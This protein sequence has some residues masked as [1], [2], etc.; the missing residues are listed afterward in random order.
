VDELWLFRPFV[1]SLTGLFAP[2]LFR[3]LARSPPGLFTPW[4]VRPLCLADSPPGLFAAWLFRPLIL[5]A[6]PLLNTGNLLNS[7]LAK[8]TQIGL[9]VIICVSKFQKY[10]RICGFHWTL[11]NKM[12]PWHSPTRGLCPWAPLGAPP[13][14]P[15]YRLAFCALAMAPFAKSSIRHWPRML[16]TRLMCQRQAFFENEFL[17]V[18]L[19]KPNNRLT[20]A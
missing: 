9:S 18:Y 4:L 7:I 13:P 12:S 2:W 10:G 17:Q 1:G 5:D 16:K 8:T 11:E 20:N 15:R 6:S 3:P 19:G 14:D